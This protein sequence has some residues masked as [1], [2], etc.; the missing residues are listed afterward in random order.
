MAEATVLGSLLV[1]LGMDS[2]QFERASQRAQSTVSKM[3]AGIGVSAKDVVTASNRMGVS[4]TAFAG[5]VQ[6]LQTRL[7]PGNQA[8]VNYR[9]EMGLLREALRIGAISQEQFRGSVQTALA[10]YRQAGQGAAAANDNLKKSTGS[11]QAGLQQLS[12]QLGDVATQFASGTKPMQI[13]AQQGT[14]VVQ[15]ISLMSNG[16][17]KF[18]AFLA[19]PWALL[20]TA[21]VTVLS[22]LV[23][24]FYATGDAADGAAGKID[25]VAD[26]LDRLS[27]A[28]GRVTMED[29]G[30]ARAN[31]Y[32]KRAAVQDAKDIRSRA[33]GN[34]GLAAGVGKLDQQVA[35]AQREY[36][37]AQD[38]LRLSQF[39]AN[40]Y[41]KSDAAD[42]A[43]A[44][45][46]S[47]R[48]Q[49]SSSG[50]NQG[51]I[52]A[53]FDD[54][55]NRLKS[56]RAQLEADYTGT[57]EAKYKASIVAIDNDLESFKANTLANKDIGSVRQQ[58]LILQAEGNADLKRRIAENDR[59]DALAARSFDYQEKDLELQMQQVQIR[60]QLAAAA[61]DQRAADLEMLDLQD[62]L[63][64]AQLDRIMATEAST[65]AAWG[66]ARAEKEALLASS[67]QRRLVVERQHM[68]PMEQYRFNLQS[69]VADINSAMENI[70]VGAINSLT[71]GIAGA[72]A[73]TQKLGDVFKNVA[74]QIVA[75]L[76]R[77]QIQKALVGA[78]GNALNFGGSSING[79]NGAQFSKGL[80]AE[81]SG[82]ASNMNVS[83]AGARAAGGPVRAGL[84][85]MIGERGPEIMVPS[86]SGQVIPNH[87]L[88]SMGG[89]MVHQVIQYSGA[90]DI[91]DRAYVNQMALAA[92]QGAMQAMDE[93]GRRRG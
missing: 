90:V 30:I 45:T 2:A 12:Y 27:K 16:A 23:S 52:A 10:S 51:Q 86:Q 4:V 28:K 80:G 5:Q 8:L 54:D 58:Q 35:D 53:R 73:G 89:V 62:K 56:E 26:A 46:K 33:G 44:A 7:N 15:A 82:W 76:I 34:I 31:V 92:K 70:E 63:K 83:L 22:A 43:A 81:I 38:L 68:T 57:I 36:V 25:G 9:R 65:S 77:I 59:D 88:G 37:K 67:G 18:G 41:K 64:I 20:V 75:D 69:S 14:Q 48:A 85:Y 66:N 3:A 79:V 91:A 71:D 24:Q 29:L 72:I 50:K 42:R 19:G 17:G 55:M 39:R 61:A 32:E 13:F 6:A 74:Q 60:G 84:P 21:G 78:L 1:Q 93:R 11:M 47:D 40:I 49:K 87:E